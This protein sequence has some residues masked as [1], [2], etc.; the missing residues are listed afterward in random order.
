MTTGPWYYVFRT[1]VCSAAKIPADITALFGPLNDA[2]W[3]VA[4]KNQRPS[5]PINFLLYNIR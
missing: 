1:P 2:L 5:C 3:A 4:Q